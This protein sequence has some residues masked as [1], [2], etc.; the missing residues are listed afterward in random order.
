MTLPVPQPPNALDPAAERAAS[1][2]ATVY[3][4]AEV[5]T[6]QGCVNLHRI[7]Q[8]A[9]VAK[10]ADTFNGVPAVILSPGPSLAENVH[11]V[12]QLKGKCL[13]ISYGRTLRTLEKHGI[14][15][16][17]A[18]AL[19]PLDLVYHFD[20][21]DVSR[22]EGLVVGAT[23]NPELYTRPWKRIFP[24]SGNQVIESW[25][26]DALPEGEEMWLDTSCSVATTSLSLARKMGCSPIVLVGQDL[27][28]PGGRYY[29]AGTA[30]GAAHLEKIPQLDS[31]TLR[32][33][34]L[35]MKTLA[36]LAQFKEPHAVAA[37]NQIHGTRSVREKGAQVKGLS[38]NAKAVEATGKAV[39]SRIGEVKK[40]PGYY[41]GFVKATPSFTWVREWIGK[42][43]AEIP[44]VVINATEGGCYIDNCVHAPLATVIEGGEVRRGTQVHATLQPLPLEDVDVAGRFDAV[45]EAVDVPAQREALRTMARDIRDGLVKA[46]RTGNEI[47]FKLPTTMPTNRSVKRMLRRRTKLERALKSTQIFASIYQQQ[48]IDTA[49]E[50]TIPEQTMIGALTRLATLAEA[51]AHAA[52]FGVPLLEDAMRRME[53]DDEKEGR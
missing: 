5:W 37:L 12:K 33:E 22:L 25:I 35:I 28:F 38:A 51:A 23:C 52:D 47:R 21:Y 53:S 2:Q 18:V 9:S 39:L 13:L 16:D 24:F 32:E 42:R 11:L 6:R 8:C 27:S 19:D 1:M 14:I 7:A 20:G 46:R 4:F 34:E 48:N 17:L 30:D 44:G 36:M 3:S 29:E 26:Y 31:E 41:G 15:P 45:V 40:V 10:L 49:V 50:Q 43:A